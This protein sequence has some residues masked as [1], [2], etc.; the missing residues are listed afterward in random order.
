MMIE[1]GM[2]QLKARGGWG[3]AAAPPTMIEKVMIQLRQK[4][5]KKQ[6]G[7]QFPS[8]RPHGTSED[9]ITGGTREELV[10]LRMQEAK[11]KNQLGKQRMRKA[12]ARKPPKAIKPKSQRNWQ[13]RG[14][15]RE[16]L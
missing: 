9:S 11:A 13:C 14:C 7:H 6:R 12:K 16:E 1:K 4:N 10:M 8:A 2:I 3:G 5:I 15:E